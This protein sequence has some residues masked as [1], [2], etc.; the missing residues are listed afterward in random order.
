MNLSILQTKADLENWRRQQLND[1]INL[2]PTMGGLHKG[3]QKLIEAA[4]SIS[5]KTSAR[6]LVSIF[7]N[8]LQFGTDEDFEQYPRNLEEDC[9][10]AFEAG[11]NAVWAPDIENVF[12]R[13]KESHITIKAPLKLKQYLCGAYRTNHF[14]GVATV[15]TQLL[16]LVRPNR[17][18]LGEKDWQ[19]LVILR[20]L[21]DDLGLPVK[22]ISIGTVRDLD[23]L[24]YSSRNLYLTKAERAQAILLPNLLKN[25]AKKFKAGEDIKLHQ[26]RS[27]LKKNKIQVEYLETVD[28]RN[29]T[30]VDHNES[31]LCMLAAAVRCGNTRLID[32]TFLMKRDPIVA[33]DG[34]AGAGKSTVTKQLAKKLGLIYLDTGAMYRAITLFI[35][36]NSLDI[37]KNSVLL[38]ALNEFNLDIKL[39]EDGSQKVILNNQDITKK[40][41]SPEITSQ[42]SLIAANKHIRQKLTDQQQKLGERGGLVAEG[43]DIGTTVF[44]KADLKVFLTATPKERAKRRAIDMKNQGF[45]VPN[46]LD[47]ENEIN[48]RDQQDASREISP[49]LKAKDAKEL[50]TDGMEIEEVIDSLI[51]MFREMVPEEIWP[52]DFE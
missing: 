36:D 15:V 3:H 52:I 21:I 40:I 8:P 41:R 31:K 39:S 4:K 32:H 9:I 49:L 30:P 44:P 13:G 11:A 28:M 12:P 45:E 42:V 10:K 51:D 20:Q 48:K 6:V 26:L 33:I 7:V 24:A 35:Q 22:I 27:I 14:D 17:M 34:P 16:S 5:S 25:A 2:V 23:G 29:L 38:R 19:Q 37:E 43:R 18:F 1:E 46:L 47:L 50:I